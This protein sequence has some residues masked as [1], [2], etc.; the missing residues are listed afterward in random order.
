M[1][2]DLRTRKTYNK[3]VKARVKGILDNGCRLCKIKPVKEFKYWKIIDNEYPWDLVAKIDHLILPKRHVVYEKLNKTEKKELNLI[4]ETYLE[5]Y[6][7]IA[8]A[9]HRKKSIP[10]HFHQHLIILKD[11][12]HKK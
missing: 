3:Y 12:L 8:E 11:S 2:Q 9:T 1:F 6:E 5:K 7:I 4:K 10:D